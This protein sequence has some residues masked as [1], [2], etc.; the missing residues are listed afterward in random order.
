V[1]GNGQLDD[2]EVQETRYACSGN[3]IAG[4]AGATADKGAAGKNA[5]ETAPI[6]K[7][8]A[9]QIIKSAILTCDAVTQRDR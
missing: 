5:P 6:G 3:S 4:P 1:K 2:D 9:T 8:L 7:F